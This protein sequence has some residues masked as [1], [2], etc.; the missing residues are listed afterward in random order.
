M[1]PPFLDSAAAGA[2]GPHAA[3]THTHRLTG[4][5]KD[6]TRAV[7][8]VRR[9]ASL[10]FAFGGLTHPSGATHD[11]LEA[12]R[13]EAAQGFTVEHELP[14]LLILHS[15]ISPFQVRESDFKPKTFTQLI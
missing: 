6:A 9:I 8:D 4:S 10:A 12:A 11:L 5:G 14:D 2:A 15:G 13:L 1:S 7:G 3:R